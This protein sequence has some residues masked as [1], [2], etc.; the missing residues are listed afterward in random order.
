MSQQHYTVKASVRIT[1]EDMGI[2][3]LVASHLINFVARSIQCDQI[4][5]NFAPLAK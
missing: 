1:E 3:Y 5:Q 2:I 4:G